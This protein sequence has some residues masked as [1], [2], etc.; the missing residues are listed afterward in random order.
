[1]KLE[2]RYRLFIRIT[3]LARKDSLYTAMAT[4]KEIDFLS[5]L[6][7][8]V[9]N[10]AGKF[11]RRASSNQPILFVS[12]INIPEKLLIYYFSYLPAH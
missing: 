11:T 5:F 6:F 2:S 7:L 8:L 12:M 3:Y 9:D 10:M 4:N 1:M